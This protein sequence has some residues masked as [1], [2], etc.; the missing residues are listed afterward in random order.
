MFARKASRALWIASRNEAARREA[1]INS[2]IRVPP[3]SI[4][5]ALARET[6]REKFAK[7]SHIEPGSLRMATS[8]ESNVARHAGKKEDARA[9]T[10]T[11]A[12][13][14]TKGRNPGF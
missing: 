3:D 9:M 4:G 14:N 12:A 11:M 13:E 8:G 2:V 7:I 1:S 6:A 10:A 5:A